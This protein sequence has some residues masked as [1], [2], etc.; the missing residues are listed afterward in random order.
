M[1]KAYRAKI[2]AHLRGPET[3][4]RIIQPQGLR[5][6]RGP[7]ISPKGHLKGGDMVEQR[8]EKKAEQLLQVKEIK[9]L[10]DRLIE[11]NKEKDL[12]PLFLLRVIMFNYAE[13][14]EVKELIKEYKAFEESLPDPKI[15]QKKYDMQ[16]REDID[17]FIERVRDYQRRVDTL[18]ELT[19]K[20][21]DIGL[22]L[23]KEG[24]LIIAWP[25]KD[26]SLEPDL[27]SEYISI[28]NSQLYYNFRRKFSAG[29]FTGEDWPEAD[30]SGSKVKG[31]ALLRPDN[32]SP[33]AKEEVLLELQKAMRDKVM[34][35]AKNGDLAVDILDIVIAKH[36]K[37]TSNPYQPVKITADDFLQARGIKKM[38]GG[39]G[40]RG[41]YKEAWRQEIA[42]YMYILSDAFLEVAE[43]EVYEYDNK[44]KRQMVS[45]KNLH[46][47]A[48]VLSSL[49]T[50]SKINEGPDILA[51]YV[52]PG[53]C[54][55]PA[56]TDPGYQVALL[57]QKALHYDYN[58][59]RYE[60]RLAR[61]FT[62]LWRM[63]KPKERLRVSTLLEEAILEINESRPGRTKDRL[64]T[65]L[66]RLQEDD[67]I[68][69]WE[70]EDPIETNKKGWLQRW[71]DS[72]VYIQIPNYLLEHY[73]KIIRPG[74]Q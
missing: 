18:N 62:H 36:L 32:I 46:S 13:G 5:L 58:K 39:G 25:K 33:V 56:L 37:T 71:L 29:S 21:L 44:G 7:Y 51:W 43:M 68:A 30:I 24:R 16:K 14:P 60:K 54:F 11:L 35:L 59:Y 9:A 40:R 50:Q 74:D 64:E 63:K 72:I 49:E 57:S 38:L 41:G 73:E 47:R 17:E 31:K 42:K 61:Y 27:L 65:A 45:K 34:D 20:A 1:A 22:Q 4:N 23:H 26:E 15:N 3:A 2:G 10:Y 53:D 69:A 8:L 52:R 67:V 6:L 66:N 48:V 55:I 12:T 70:Y 28:A 19:E